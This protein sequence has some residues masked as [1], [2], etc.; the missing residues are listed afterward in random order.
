MDVTGKI[1]DMGMDYG[2][3][4][5]KAT[6][7]FDQYC[8]EAVEELTRH[9]KLRIKL[10]KYRK[11]RSKE[12]NAYFWELCGKL[13]EKLQAPPEELYRR[14]VREVGG[15]YEVIPIKRE[16]ADTFIKNWGHNR[17]GWICEVL[18]DNRKYPDFVNVIAYYGSSVYDTAQMARLIDI[19]VEEC[20]AQGIP[21]ET[22]EEIARM[23]ADWRAADG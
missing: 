14:M 7:L 9:E 17:L 10:T 21:T 1:I 6:L 23:K 11:Q 2:T 19:I 18:G 8:G 16:A 3:R 5:I 20:K 15:N 4:H 12:A 13:A 22:P